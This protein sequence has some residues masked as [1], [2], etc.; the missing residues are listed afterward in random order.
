MLLY[1]QVQNIACLVVRYCCNGQPGP[2]MATAADITSLTLADTARHAQLHKT[3][4]M[5]HKRQQSWHFSCRRAKFQQ[6]DPKVLPPT[7][8]NSG[9]L[10]WQGFGPDNNMY[11]WEDYILHSCFQEFACLIPIPVKPSLPKLLPLPCFA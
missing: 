7:S 8:Q 1:G 6:S 9:G 5:P 10:S 4:L 11:Y 3:Y 2:Q